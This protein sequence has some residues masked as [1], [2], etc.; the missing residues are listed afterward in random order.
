MAEETVPVVLSDETLSI[1]PK[2]DDVVGGVVSVGGTLELMVEDVTETIHWNSE[3]TGI[4]TVEDGVVT[5]VKVGSTTI[6][7]EC[8]GKRGEYPLTVEEAEAPA[9]HIELGEN[10]E[11]M[12]AGETVTLS[13][14]VV[15][16]DD[17]TT[18]PEPLIIW[19]L[20]DPKD[21]EYVTLKSNGT[22]SALSTLRH[23]RTI[24]LRVSFVDT[25]LN[26]ESM[27]EVTI[28]VYPR[29]SEIK[30]LVDDSDEKIEDGEYLFNLN[31]GS[32]TSITVKANLFPD[33]ET[34]AAIDWKVND[35]R[36]LC[37]WFDG[38]NNDSIVITPNDREKTGTVTVI[39][40]AKDG[41]GVSAKLTIRF[42]KLAE[43][44]EIKGA[45]EQMRGGSSVT[46]TT[47]VAS[48]KDLTDKTILWS[49]TDA[50][51]NPT[52]AASIN[53]S[54]KLTA[55]RLADDQESVIVCVH[56]ETEMGGVEAT[57]VEIK[58]VHAVEDIEIV[59]P[60]G[61]NAGNVSY[62]EETVQLDAIV[63]LENG[64]V[65]DKQ[66]VTWGTSNK[67]IA[68]IDSD[69]LLTIYNAGKVRISATAKDGSK[70]VGYI[71]L[72]ITKPVKEVL[73]NN[74]A[75]PEYLRSGK[76]ATMK[77]TAWTDFGKDVKAA[78]QKMKWEVFENV[79]GI[80]EKTSKATIT[81]S[82][83]L[84]VKEIKKNA[85][86]VVRATSVEKAPED[87]ID[88][89]ND[90]GYAFAEYT[91]RIKP[92]KRT[93][94]LL[95]M[96]GELISENTVSMNGG[97]EAYIEG[98]LYDS[99][100]AE[101]TEE[102]LVDPDSTTFDSS[103]ESVATI[104]EYGDI[105]TLKTGTTT[106]TVKTRDAGGTLYTTK[107]TL[108]VTNL[109]EEVQITA[110]KSTDLRGGQSLTLK[111]TAW[112]NY[113]DLKASNQKI[114]WRLVGEDGKLTTSTD[115]ASISSSGRVTAKTVTENTPVTVVATSVENPGAVDSVELM[116][117]PKL[118]CTMTAYFANLEGKDETGTVYV[119]MNLINAD[120]LRNY[121]TVNAYIS[122]PGDV[123]DD[124]L[125]EITDAVTWS[126]SS[127]SIVKVDSKTGALQALK[128]G[129]VT[130]TAK[131]VKEISGKKTNFS[132][133]IT[134][135]L[136]NA[137]TEIDIVQRVN[138]QKL[139]AGKT[140][141]LRAITNP[142]ATNKRVKWSLEDDTYA[143]I[144]PDSGVIT[145]K[146]TVTTPQTLIVH[147]K[148][149]DGYGAEE[150]EALL[151]PI[152]PLATKILPS[153]DGTPVD[154]DVKKVDL[155]LGQEYTLG[156]TTE[157]DGAAT[158]MKWTSSRTT[159][160][161]IK[162]DKDTNSYVL[163]AKKKGTAVIKAAAQDGS[164]K[165]VSFTV[166]VS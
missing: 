3:D 26:I 27:P 87:V 114:T 79:D 134:L 111:A 116:I 43:T 42:V 94:F 139:Y 165:T 71:Y 25:K 156:A 6:Y 81:S 89:V 48:M 142:N 148:A 147:A 51:G 34:D 61:I 135:V 33:G 92:A 152:Y 46:L 13:A 69:G 8:D 159:V 39:A 153:V 19:S 32:L 163:E 70:K 65:D 28:D 21:D 58:I 86:I 35:T 143:T 36:N 146:R 164:G 129:K 83:R 2:R 133:K 106:I 60:D 10:P 137:V 155:D 117:R 50:A 157:P 109:V 115:A 38:G 96:D 74:G 144:N 63:T 40:T 166:V 119:P 76:S 31:D 64:T 102:T 160:A 68:S 123:E 84:S 17:E 161:Y 41:S 112:T 54:G 126:T 98:Y 62:D 85:T 90:D 124:D 107:F 103:K 99:D 140:L 56:A 100:A 149:V 122:I 150:A 91:L 72:T 88:G 132:T 16:D 5:G 12:L 4:A 113:D 45:P 162:W 44:V 141:A 82:G 97:T 95:K 18:L 138:N 23:K 110:P 67:N 78:N 49:V 158:D 11:K 30:L 7:A 80:L 127:K 93:T 9:Y 131:Y 101:G 154:M 125:S 57:P 145:A 29:V 59:V 104:N 105:K 128:A 136:V 108:K 53:A 1:V 47:N 52:K 37:K 130:L 55:A 121:L 73:F 118:A 20:V 151:V 120:D 14:T 66:T 75:N 22:L 15:C 77:A 24:K